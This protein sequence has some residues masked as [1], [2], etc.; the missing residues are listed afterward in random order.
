MDAAAA[1][2]TR[3]KGGKRRPGKTVPAHYSRC[4]RRPA[5]VGRTLCVRCFRLPPCSGLDC[6]RRV[7]FAGALCPPCR[8]A[9]FGVRTEAPGED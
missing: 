7:D 5:E 8:T 2:Q 1:R 4:A 9:V 3:R 6:R